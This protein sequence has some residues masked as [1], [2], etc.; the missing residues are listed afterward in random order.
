MS[1][2][3]FKTETRYAQ[4]EKE[5]LAIILG[6]ER[7]D[8]YAY[9]RPI[10]VESDHKPLEMINKKALQAAPKRLQRMLLRAQRYEIDIIYKKGCHMYIADTLSRA[11]MQGNDMREDVEKEVETIHMADYL[12]ISDSRLRDIQQNTETDDTLQTLK[13]A[14]LHGWP[15]KSCLPTANRAYYGIR[16]ELTV[17][18]GIV[19]RGSRCVIPSPQRSEIL[20][21]LHEAHL[22]IEATMRR[23]RECVFWPG[24]STQIKDYISQ[25]DICSAYQSCQTKE[26]IVSHQIP[27][28]IWA[29]VG[30]DLF[31]CNDRNYIVTVAYNS[32]YF[33]IDRLENK[34]A[35]AVI[36]KLKQ[37][38][39]RHGIPDEVVSDNGPPYNSHEF[40]AFAE[41]Y[42]FDHTTSSP[43]YAQSNGKAES[44]V[45]IA[46]KLMI[47]AREAGTDPYL[48]LLNYRNTPTE[49]MDSSPAQR[50][51]GRRTKTTLP[52][53]KALLMPKTVTN[54]VEKLGD[55]RKKQANYY[56]RNAKQ[57]PAFKDGDVVCMQPAK[58]KSRWQKATVQRQANIRSYDVVTDYG[59]VYRR[60]R[61]HLRRT[62]APP[63]VPDVT[64][65]RAADV[66]DKVTDTLTDNVTDTATGGIPVRQCVDKPSDDHPAIIT[67][68][69]TVERRS[70]RQVRRPTHLRDYV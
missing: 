55:K 16:D 57:L 9:G 48:A 70:G 30:T 54:T 69:P 23:A 3:F 19:F 7:F 58:Y 26:P 59:T 14:I 52:T 31:E 32:S 51:F 43:G 11:Y 46:K 42:H 21:K 27:E 49:G 18:D 1:V 35:A 28:R 37:Q 33:E 34:T 67:A 47:K 38:F 63:A 65:P 2:S 62:T 17:Q 24:M 53:V 39:A 56:N 15:E 66:T 40:R 5:M 41:L 8:H 61:R 44:A 22:G 68:T 64:T 25:C 36:P 60:N 10:T 20:E 50:L 12:P 4:I 45:K 13:A 6:L 29:K